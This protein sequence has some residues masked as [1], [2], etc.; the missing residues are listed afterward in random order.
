VPTGMNTGVSITPCGVFSCPRRAP[1]GS[2]SKTSK[3]KFTWLVYQ[4]KANAIP[5]RRTT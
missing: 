5:T 4:E 2:F 1:V 3:E